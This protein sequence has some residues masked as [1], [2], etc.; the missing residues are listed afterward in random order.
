MNNSHLVRARHASCG[1]LLG[2]SPAGSQTQAIHIL[3]DGCN[4][5]VEGFELAIDCDK[6]QAIPTRSKRPDLFVLRRTS[7]K[8]EWIVI[9]IKDQM[10]GDAIPQI[11]AGLNVIATSS[12]FAGLGVESVSALLAYVLQVRRTASVNRLRQPLS[13]ERQSVLVTLHQCGSDVI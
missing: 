8:S 10:D 9:E 11:R 5:A 13:L 4:L 3:H 2:A 12:Y 1:C 7:G 6:C